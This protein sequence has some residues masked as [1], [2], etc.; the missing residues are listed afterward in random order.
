MA[1][2]RPRQ[3]WVY[4]IDPHTV[5]L[6]CKNGHRYVY[7]IPEPGM[8]VCKHGACNLPIN[9]SRVFRGEHP[10]IVWSSNKFHDTYNKIDVYT[11]I[12]LTTSE[13]DKGLP[14][15][16]PIKSTSRNGLS[17]NSFALVHQICT[18]DAN[19]FK[20]LNG[21][22][23]QRVGQL[24]KT[25]KRAIEKRLKYYFDIQEN[26]GDDWFANNASLELLDKVFGHLPHDKQEEAIL[27]LIDRSKEA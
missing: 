27:N 24:D 13:R 6:R 4:W 1:G 23:K 5:V 20:D 26:P 19:C 3:G 16:Y 8:V 25:D 17:K 11:A 18:L 10:Y 2:Q 7:G 12:P 22:W 14:T 21:T 9:S 15:T